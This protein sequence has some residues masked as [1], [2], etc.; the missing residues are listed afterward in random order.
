[1]KYLT[2]ICKDATILRNETKRNETKRNET[3]RNETKRN[4]HTYAQKGGWNRYVLISA[5]RVGW[6]RYLIS[7]HP[8]ILC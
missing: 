2:S 4:E 5:K 3:K 1:M 6:Q 8:V 7:N